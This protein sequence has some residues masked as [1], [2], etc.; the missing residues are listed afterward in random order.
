M[1]TE[2][3]PGYGWGALLER[4]VP[5]EC[6][7]NRE[8]PLMIPPRQHVT[9]MTTMSPPSRPGRHPCILDQAR[10]PRTPTRPHIAGPSTRS[11]E[12]PRHVFAAVV[13]LPLLDILGHGNVGTGMSTRSER[14]RPV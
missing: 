4:E 6:K 8:Y 2:E 12:L 10:H 11:A 1:L 5:G 14:E 9:A 13:P 3:H 7:Y